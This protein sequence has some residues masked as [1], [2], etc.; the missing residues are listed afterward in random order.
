MVFFLKRIKFVSSSNI[1]FKD[2]LH[3]K[4]KKQNLNY[5]LFAATFTA[6]DSQPKYLSDTVR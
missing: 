2:I 5:L 4:Y 1:E 6:C 3:N